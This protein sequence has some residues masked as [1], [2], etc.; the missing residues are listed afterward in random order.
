MNCR[1]SNRFIVF[2]FR[3]GFPDRIRP[4]HEID[5]CF[6]STQS[7]AGRSRKTGTSRPKISSE[8]AGNR[9]GIVRKYRWPSLQSQE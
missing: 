2:A 8:T 9:Q 5:A 7:R 4:G 3:A 6:G 1:V